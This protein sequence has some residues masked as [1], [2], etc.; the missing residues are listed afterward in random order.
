MPEISGPE[1]VDRLRA[2]WPELAVIYMSGYTESELQNRGIIEPLDRTGF[3][4]KPFLPAQLGAKLQEVL[5]TE[6]VDEALR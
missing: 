3:L 6:A 4:S 2:M 1:I 5:G